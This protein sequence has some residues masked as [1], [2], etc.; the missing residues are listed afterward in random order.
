MTTRKEQQNRKCWKDDAL[1]DWRFK[2]K[3][4]TIE[5]GYKSRA[6][7]RIACADLERREAET[8]T[9]HDTTSSDSTE[10]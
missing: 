10:K 1:G 9:N 7:A 8:A 5:G 3:A 4:G 6:A 2:T